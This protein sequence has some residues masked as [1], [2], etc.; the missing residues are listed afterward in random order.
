MPTIQSHERPLKKQH[1][2]IILRVEASSNN[3]PA[4]VPEAMLPSHDKERLVE[5]RMIFS[6]LLL[7]DFSA[8]RREDKHS[9]NDAARTECY[10]VKC[11]VSETHFAG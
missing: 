6:Q 5:V 9:L 4:K 1:P 10:D 3:H 11:R 8:R 7:L 2:D